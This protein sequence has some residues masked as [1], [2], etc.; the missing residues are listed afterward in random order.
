MSVKTIYPHTRY[1]VKMY[2]SVILVFGLFIL[3]WILLGLIPKLGWLY[4]LIFLVANVLWIVPTFLLLPAYFKS[5]RYEIGESELVVHQGIFTRSVKTIPYRTITDLAL[6]RD[7]LDRWLFNTASLEVQ[8]A[9]RSGQEGPEARL[10]GLANWEE[11]RAELVERLRAY[12]AGTGVGAEA[13]AQ[14]QSSD[15]SRELLRQI[16]A[17]L[18]GLRE[19][20]KE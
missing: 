5:L 13:E 2:A 12:R 18:R 6:K 11:L 15:E 9:G 16:L 7:I 1:L 17:E 10:V 19:D 14:P 4:V 8:T 3:P 20:L